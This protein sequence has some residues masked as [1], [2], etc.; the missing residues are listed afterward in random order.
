MMAG[1]ERARVEFGDYQTPARLAE[2]VC[3]V[4]KRLGFAPSSVVEPTCGSGAF[5][6]A[7]IRAFSSARRFLGVDRNPGHLKKARASLHGGRRGG[8]VEVIQSDFFNTDWRSLMEDLPKPLLVIGNPPW[9]TNAALGVLGSENRPERVNDDEMQ[10]IEALTGRSNFDISEW[11]LRR[12]LDWISDGDGMLAVL[13]KTAVARRVLMH[14]WIQKIAVESCRVYRI[15]A[16]AHFNVSVEACLLVIKCQGSA[17]TEECG[18]YASVRETSPETTFGIRDGLLVADVRRYERWQGLMSGGL[19]GWRSGVKHDCSRVFELSRTDGGYKN[20]LGE[21]VDVEPEVVFPLLKS[22]DLARKR[23]PRK[24]LLVPQKRM[25]ALPSELELC[26][27]KAWS[28]LVANAKALAKRSSAIYRGREE[29][30]IFGVGDYS[31]AP[32]KVAISGLYKGLNFTRVSPFEGRP[33]VFD[34]TCYF[35]SCRSEEEC[36]VLH[37]LAESEAAQE[38]WSAFVFWDMK[39][40]V[41]AQILNLLDLAALGR[42]LGIDGGIV[43]VLAERQSVHYT[44]GP[45][46]QLLFREHDEVQYGGG[47][48]IEIG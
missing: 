3:G 28:Y 24:W 40:P 18:K 25:A 5:L 43:R 16:K 30:S 38:F 39:R 35:F 6:R 22:S 27:P 23:E 19:S 45:R 15:D 32:W 14:A 7:A 1:R 41:T 29:F 9:V 11:M 20:G 17:R 44:E 10:G 34:D 2:E 36:G 4:V 13:C 26:A 46:Q 48:E 21:G 31:F 12:N 42:V 37:E 47:E 33:V 8:E